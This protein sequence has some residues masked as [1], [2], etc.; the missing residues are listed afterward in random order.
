MTDDSAAS[1]FAEQAR[2]VF[3]V[4]GRNDAARKAM[5]DFLRALGLQPIEWLQ[6]INWTGQATPYIGQVLDTA[7]DR[8]Q[9][10]VVLMTPDEVAYL[11]TEYSDGSSDTETQPSAQARPNVL[12][13]AGMAMGRD[14]QRTL[15]VELVEVRPFSDVAGRHSVRISN[16]AAKRQDL[17]QRLSAAGCTIDLTGTDW[18]SAGD[19][20]IPPPP[21]G[22]LSSRPTHTYRRR[23]SRSKT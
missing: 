16:D 11:R 2:R 7:F 3:V 8:A 4:H 19:F 13:E 15:L 20:T 17:A 14:A 12:F 23:T 1:S 18:L 21:G 10:I 9:A 6:A 5:F 22:G